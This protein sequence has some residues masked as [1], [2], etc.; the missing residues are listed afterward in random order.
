MTEPA[1]RATPRPAAF[2]VLG[3]LALLVGGAVWFSGVPELALGSAAGI[4]G[5]LMVLAGAVLA[6][7][8]Q[9]LDPSRPY[10]RLRPLP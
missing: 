4:A 2:A 8:I 5:A 10:N 6:P 1:L 9:W 3:L 7:L